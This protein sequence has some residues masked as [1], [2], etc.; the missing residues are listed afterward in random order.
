MNKTQEEKGSPQIEVTFVILGE[1][2][3]AKYNPNMKLKGVVQ[4][5]LADTGNTGQPFPKWELRTEDGRI[6]DMG[7]SFKEEN[8]SSGSNLFLSLK[9]GK[10]GN[11]YLSS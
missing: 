3:T 5:V 7:K 4:K 6:L 11:R 10:G 1:S 2:V 9:A 8:I